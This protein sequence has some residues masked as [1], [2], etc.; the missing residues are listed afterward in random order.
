LWRQYKKTHKAFDEERVT[1]IAL[2]TWM[3]IGGVLF[4]IRPNRLTMYGDLFPFALFVAFSLYICMRRLLTLSMSR[5]LVLVVMFCVMGLST[6]YV[7]APYRFNGSVGYF[8]CLAALALISIAL[9]RRHHVA[10]RRFYAITGLFACSLVFR[11]IDVIVCPTWHFGT[12][13]LWHIC[14][15]IVVYLLAETIGER[16]IAERQ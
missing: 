13:F 6:M 9:C 3:G 4:H 1:L 8:P 11:S 12:Y 10:A 5:T 7:P 16:R 15:G 2:I 14:N